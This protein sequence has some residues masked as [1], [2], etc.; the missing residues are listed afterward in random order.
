MI[1]FNNVAD[2]IK[3]IL[4]EQVIPQGA[5]RFFF[6]GAPYLFFYLALVQF[7][8]LPLDSTTV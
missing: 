8:V 1:E 7:L 5:N 2:G 3:L 4:K 6:L